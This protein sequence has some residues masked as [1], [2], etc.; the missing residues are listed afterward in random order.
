MKVISTKNGI[1]LPVICL[2]F[3]LYKPAIS[4]VTNQPI[5]IHSGNKIYYKDSNA[6]KLDREFKLKKE[7]E[8]ARE[9]ISPY[10]PKN[11]CV[12]AC[13]KSN[14]NTPTNETPN[15]TNPIKYEVLPSDTD[16]RVYKWKDKNGVIHVTND[17]GAVPQ[18]VR[19]QIEKEESQKL[20]KQQKEH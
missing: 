13:G 17:L 6:E 18:E 5:E 4:Q 19:D 12:G 9:N 8:K 7:I 20:R 3:L 1:L 10:T 16:N 2:M 11:S 14:N 15:V